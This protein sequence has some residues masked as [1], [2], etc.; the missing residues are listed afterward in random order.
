MGWIKEVPYV[1]PHNSCNK[2]ASNG[3]KFGKGSIWKCDDCGRVW[4]FEGAKEH[5]DQ[6]EGSWWTDNW[7]MITDPNNTEP[8]YDYWGR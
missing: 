6:R 1:H 3:T 2:P 8:I 5:H 4:K 7:K